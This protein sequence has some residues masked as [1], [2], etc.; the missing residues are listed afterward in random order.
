MLIG[1]R[2]LWTDT[3]TVVPLPYAKLKR[4]DEHVTDIVRASRKL[5]DQ[6]E[7]SRQATNKTAEPLAAT[8]GNGLAKAPTSASTRPDE[9][10]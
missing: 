3:D 7:Q 10:K 4:V 5:H 8:F 6:R 2:S 1:H 9:Y